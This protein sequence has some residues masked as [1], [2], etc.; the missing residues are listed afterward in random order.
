LALEVLKISCS[1]AWELI[2]STRTIFH[3]EFHF[4]EQRRDQMR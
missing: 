2:H 4:F 1:K 3:S